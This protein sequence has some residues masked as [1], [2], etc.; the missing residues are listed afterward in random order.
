M[1]QYKM[2]GWHSRPNLKAVL[3][4]ILWSSLPDSSRGAKYVF[5]LDDL[6][7]Q[8]VRQIIN[9][10]NP[11]VVYPCIIGQLAFF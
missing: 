5:S 2:N 9:N 7:K 11:R 1:P 6:N 10:K 8:E 3:A 4:A